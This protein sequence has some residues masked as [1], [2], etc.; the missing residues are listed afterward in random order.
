M[1]G[2][3]SALVLLQMVWELKCCE[4]RYDTFPQRPDKLVE[5]WQLACM[6]QVEDN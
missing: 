4:G 3:L 6:K 1:E 5:Q 2:L